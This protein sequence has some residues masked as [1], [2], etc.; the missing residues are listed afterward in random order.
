LKA[1]YEERKGGGCPCILRLNNLKPKRRLLKM[2]KVNLKLSLL[3]TQ[4]TY[5]LKVFRCLEVEHIASLYPNK[6]VMI[7]KYHK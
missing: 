6:R 1:E 4:P 7:L 5:N 2:L 3:Q